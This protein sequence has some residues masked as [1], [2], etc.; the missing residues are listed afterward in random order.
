MLYA[1]LLGTYSSRIGKYKV[2]S[3]EILQ[4]ASSRPVQLVAELLVRLTGTKPPREE[5]D[6]NHSSK[7]RLPV[8]ATQPC[9]TNPVVPIVWPRP[10]T[11]LVLSRPFLSIS[12]KRHIPKLVNTNGIPHLRFKKPQSPFLSR[13]IRDKIRQREKRFD[14]SQLLKAE[15]DMAR[16]EDEWDSILKHNCGIED[17]DSGSWIRAPVIALQEVKAKIQDS[18][19]KNT[20]LGRKM[21]DIIEM[22]KALAEKEQGNVVNGNVPALDI[23]NVLSVGYA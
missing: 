16:A 21:Y 2:Q 15:I 3:L 5:E 1:I 8:E 19:L 6:S 14:R 9:K 18:H 12:G 22:E 4:Y 11:P 7:G 23:R 17:D 20:E 10:E 13:V